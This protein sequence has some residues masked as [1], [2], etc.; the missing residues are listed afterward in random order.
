MP[1]LERHGVGANQNVVAASVESG[2]PPWNVELLD[3]MEHVPVESL[4]ALELPSGA[5]PRLEPAAGDHALMRWGVEV[6]RLLKLR[7]RSEREPLVHALIEQLRNDVPAPSSQPMLTARDLVEVARSH[8]VGVHSSTTTRWSSKATS[9]S[10]RTSAVAGAG[11][12]STSGPSLGST[13]FRTAAT[14]RPR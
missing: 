14:G 4:R 13:P 11:T 7:P 10:P 9:S 5:L 6:S 3:A 12:A 2:R 1:I 8:E